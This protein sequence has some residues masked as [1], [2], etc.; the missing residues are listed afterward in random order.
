MRT[1]VIIIAVIIVLILGVGG[2]ILITS[3]RNQEVTY[4]TPTAKTQ[5]ST[6]SAMDQTMEVIYT[7]S[8][9]MPETITVKSGSTITFTN[10][11]TKRMWVA[12]DPHPVHTNYSGFDALKGYGQ[13]E[14]YL[15]TFD[16][17][18]TWNYHDH[19]NPSNK[20]IIIVK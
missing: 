14:T 7:D 16:Q 8:G 15:F 4:Q 11:S 10:N 2:F 17:V 1:Q 6:E 12:S 13:D 18:G 5:N 3:T 20:G 9:F 19:L